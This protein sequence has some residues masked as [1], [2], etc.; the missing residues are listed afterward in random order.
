MPAET[1]NSD[2]A[3]LKAVAVGVTAFVALLWLIQATV[4]VTGWDPG[5]LGLR[6]RD[7]SGLVGILTA[8]LVHGSWGHLFG[9]TLALL[10]LGMAVLY[11]TP[12]AGRI[13]LP[14]I[15]LASGL[16]VWL[17]ARE[18]V[19]VGASGL[20]YGMFFF[21]FLMGILRRDKRSIALSLLVFFL[22]GSMVWGVL[23]TAPGVSFEYH[24][25][26][27]IAGGLSAF[28]LRHR[29]PMPQR[30][31]YDWEYEDEDEAGNDDLWFDRPDPD[32]E[33]RF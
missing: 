4:A 22:Y 25:Y 15:W 27:A 19:H 29:D 5:P 20:T 7:P 10:V 16:A 17:F 24:L 9:N 2:I 3:R 11:G 12:A 21:V 26:G 14:L 6:P 32:S 13:G 28:L 23:P 30:R 8:P 33:R 1:Q 31:R 18:G